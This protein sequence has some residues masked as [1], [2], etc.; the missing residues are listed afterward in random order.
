MNPFQRWLREQVDRVG[1]TVL[2]ERGKFTSGALQAWLRGSFP[3]PQYQM[4]LTAA[5][6]IDLDTLRLLVW[7][8]ER[9]AEEV[10]PAS[11]SFRPR[12]SN[13]AAA[14]PTP[15]PQSGREPTPARGRGP[16]ARTTRKDRTHSFC[17]VAP[18]AAAP[19]RRSDQAEAA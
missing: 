17:H 15:R 5:T 2:C 13:G 4:K 16:I 6:G 1:W 19:Q 9:L 3:G 11:K 18:T 12:R 8:S 7:E 14:A 10:E